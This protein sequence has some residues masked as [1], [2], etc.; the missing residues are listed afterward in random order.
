M[1]NLQHHKSI[2][3]NANTMNVIRIRCG[4]SP[5]S[6]TVDDNAEGYVSVGLV[7]G[8]CTTTEVGNCRPLQTICVPIMGAGVEVA[9]PEPVEPWLDEDE[10]TVGLTN[11]PGC[12]MLSLESTV[13]VFV[14]FHTFEPSG[15]RAYD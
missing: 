10:G 4:V 13:G 6:F 11:G 14:I 1:N 2:K 7:T 5:P 9:Y 3:A 15:M 8:V 12:V